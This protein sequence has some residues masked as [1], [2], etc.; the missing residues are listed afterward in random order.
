MQG[1]QIPGSVTSSGSGSGATAGRGSTALR[2]HLLAFACAFIW[3]VTFIS[4]KILLVGLTAVEVL[5]LRFAV[6]YVSLW[7]VR[8]R[9]FR[10][11]GWKSEAVFAVLGATGV[12]LYFLLENIAL[13]YTTASNVSVIVSTAP[14]ATAIVGTL[15]FKAGRLTPQFFA[16]FVLAIAGIAIISFTGGAFELGILGC[17]AALLSAVVWAVYSNVLKG[18]VE[19]Y[20]DTVLIAR[21]TV[22]W[23]LLFMVPAAAFD[24]FS[25]DWAFL[26]DSG[27]VFHLL[28]LGLFASALTYVMW[29]DAVQALGTIKSSAYIY[30]SPVFTIVAGVA[31]L[32]EP[33]TPTIAGGCAL[34]I[35]GLVVS[36]LRH[37]EPEPAEGL[38]ESPAEGLAE[39]EGR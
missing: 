3:G 17:L 12:A 20:G 19:R 13:L 38:A 25:P 10:T 33:F 18:V 30:L 14:L 7:I 28:F 26:F 15:F 9:L 21:R 36:Q 29:S 1:P 34:T 6:G 16:G 32:A 11:G 27:R 39:G 35:A 4:T 23:G 5:V 24:G 8:P 31:V 37:R 2:G 22:F